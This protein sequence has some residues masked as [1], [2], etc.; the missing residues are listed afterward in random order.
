MKIEHKNLDQLHFYDDHLNTIKKTLL[1]L[2]PIKAF[3]LRTVISKLIVKI[4]QFIF[5]KFEDRR[6]YVTF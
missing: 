3:I 5:I 1:N 2:L 4:I 6:G